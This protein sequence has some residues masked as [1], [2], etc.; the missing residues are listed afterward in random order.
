MHTVP[1]IAACSTES[2]VQAATM[3]H[4]CLC[5]SVP[6]KM[7]WPEMGEQRR[8]ESVGILC[9]SFGRIANEPCK[10]LIPLEKLRVLLDIS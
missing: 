8:R 2:G 1:L 9:L 4:E 10:D 6:G 7:I 5:S 3:S